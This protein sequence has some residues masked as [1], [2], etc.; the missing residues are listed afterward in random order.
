MQFLSQFLESFALHIKITYNFF[1]GLEII[2]NVIKINYY[3][4]IMPGN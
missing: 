2:Y 3:E 1:T 4:N